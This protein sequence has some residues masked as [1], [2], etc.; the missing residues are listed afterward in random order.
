MVEANI[1]RDFTIGNTRI[2]I[3]DDYCRTAGGSQADIERY[4][5]TGSTAVDSSSFNQALWTRGKCEQCRQW[6]LA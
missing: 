2:K 4:S 3:A 6:W 1:V 5:G